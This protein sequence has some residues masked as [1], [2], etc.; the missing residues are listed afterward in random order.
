M[1]RRVKT[2][3]ERQAVNIEYSESTDIQAKQGQDGQHSVEMMICKSQSRSRK[4]PKSGADKRS[5]KCDLKVDLFLR[6]VRRGNE[7][8]SN[9]D[10]GSGEAIHE[11]MRKTR[12]NTLCLPQCAIGPC[13]HAKP[14]A[15]KKALHRDRG[16]R[17]LSRTSERLHSRACEFPSVGAERR[18]GA[19][20]WEVIQLLEHRTAHPL[21]QRRAT[22]YWSTVQVPYALP[23]SQYKFVTEHRRSEHLFERNDA[24]SLRRDQLGGQFSRLRIWT[25]TNGR[26]TDFQST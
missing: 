10:S 15:H 14:S 8:V 16:Y 24:Q 21:F 19:C 5:K 9:G 4:R 6:H 25:P 7:E 26:T 1:M 18:R 2:A 17:G 22:E 12:L 13:S 11:P 20:H 23:G 3:S